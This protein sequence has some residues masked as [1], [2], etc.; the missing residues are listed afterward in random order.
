MLDDSEGRLT[1]RV[2]L[3]VLTRIFPRDLVDEVL[4]ATGKNEQR[5]RLLPARVVVYYVLALTLFYGDAYEEVLQKLVN[6]LR[7]LRSWRSDWTVPSTSAISRARDRLGPLPL[8]EL[9]VRVAQPIACRRSGNSL[10]GR[11]RNSLVA[12]GGVSTGSG[13][14]WPGVVG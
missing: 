3:G 4:N 1:E 9:F 5:K 11:S 6:G 10:P 2:G 7:F 8:R 14:V 13:L 12:R